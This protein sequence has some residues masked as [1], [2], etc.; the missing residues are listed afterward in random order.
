MWQE[1]APVFEAARGYALDFTY[2]I[3]EP[4]GI[5]LGYSRDPIKRL[6]SLQ[7]GNPRPLVIERLLLGGAEME[8]LLHDR[9][10]LFRRDKGEWFAPE[11]R[12]N[13]FSVIEAIRERQLRL[14]L[15]DWDEDRNIGI[16]E[17][18]HREFGVHATAD[19]PR[20]LSR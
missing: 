14:S 5:K 18:V 16:A 11:A 8:A 9:W 1:V 4:D 15:E 10:S 13:L 12:K 7:C 17:D 19:R 20:L 6:R 2:C 3:C